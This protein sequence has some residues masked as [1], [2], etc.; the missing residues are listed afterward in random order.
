MQQVKFFNQGGICNPTFPQYSGGGNNSLGGAQTV[1]HDVR[2][3]LG[4]SL[5]PYGDYQGTGNKMIN[6]QSEYRKLKLCK[7]G[8]SCERIGKGCEYGHEIIKK[9]CRSGMRCGRKNTCLF[10]HETTTER[11]R[12]VLNEHG[13]MNTKT[14][15]AGMLPAYEF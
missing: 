1:F 15:P 3:N 5:N 12:G 4:P 8:K 6:N 9:L 13:P 2:G 10:M 14:C 7:F 11:N